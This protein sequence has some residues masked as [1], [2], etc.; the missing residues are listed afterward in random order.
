MDD[1]LRPPSALVIYE[2][3]FGNTERVARAIADGLEAAGYTVICLDVG[4]PLPVSL[5][6]DLLVLGAPTHAFSLSR[7]TTRADAVKQGAPAA[8]GAFGLREWLSDIE[9]ERLGNPAV[10]VFDTRVGKVRRLPAAAGRT[11]RRIARRRGFEVA[12][13]VEPFLVADTPGPLLPGEV[14]RAKRWGRA[15][16]EERRIASRTA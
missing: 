9:P 13:P 5:D 11:T 1:R 16:G 10:A 3:M 12:S 8:R 15:L 6:L 14:E 2:S 7:P 4:A